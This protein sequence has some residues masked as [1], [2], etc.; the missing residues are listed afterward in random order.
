[1]RRDRR[2]RLGGLLTATATATATIWAGCG[3]A[4]EPEATARS[5]RVEVLR[6]GP[7]AVSAP[8]VRPTDG[9]GWF[10]NGYPMGSDVTS[11]ASPGGHFRVWYAQ[12]GDQAVDLSDQDGDKVPDFVNAV[13]AAADRTY[14][15]TVTERGFRPPLNDSVYNDG[16][17]FGTDDRFDIYLRWAQKGSDGYRVV[18]KCT[19]AADPPPDR[20]AGY[21]VMNPSFK[22][23]SYKTERDGIE[24]LTSH[25]LFHALQDAY[26]ASVVRTF[27]EG[28]AVWNELQVFPRD[29]DKGRE[30]TWRD[31]LGFLPAL[32]SEPERPFDKSLGTGPGTSYAYATAAWFE[33]LSER[34]GPRL[35]REIWEGSVADAAGEGLSFLEVSEALLR[36]RYKSDLR[37]EW[38]E[39]TR[40]NLLTGPRA[41]LGTMTGGPRSYR[42][43]VEYP[44]VRLEPA[45][46]ALGTATP[47]SLDGLS[48]RYLPLRPELARTSRLRLKVGDGSATPAVVT[49]YV[50]GRGGAPLGPASV[51]RD[52]SH[53]LTLTPG[54]ELIAVV[55]GVV[56]GARPYTVTLTLEELASEPEGNPKEEGGCGI[57]APRPVRPAPLGLLGVALALARL[58]RRRSAGR[59]T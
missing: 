42:D 15:S 50:K 17:G 53:E 33:F 8:R 25:E 7:G 49:V 21:F 24:V 19:D 34:H 48:A 9:S 6:P 59:S 35:V 44:A 43:A 1:M 11:Y 12:K 57:G 58:R 52:G 51:V 16:R 46:T 18:E 36:D 26:R 54:D 31:Y 14:E 38:A 23:S 3:A 30:G 10:G 4:P 41:P 55:S 13:A 40:W 5:E 27:S 29:K 56:R 2:T 28:T 39:F 47:L 45:V 32:F 20:C 22:G 37:D